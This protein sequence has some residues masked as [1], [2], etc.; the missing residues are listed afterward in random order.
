MSLTIITYKKRA[1]SGSST[2]KEKFSI[3][4]MSLR[5]LISVPSHEVT[6]R[7]PSKNCPLHAKAV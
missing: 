5:S 7:C 3:S 1:S 2:V 6:R 4:A